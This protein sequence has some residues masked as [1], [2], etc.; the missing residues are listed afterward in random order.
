MELGL[1]KRRLVM[2]SLAGALR[3]MLAVPLYLVLTP[4]ML[5]ELGQEMFGLWS[6]STLIISVMTLTDFGFKNALVYHIARAQGQTEA[7]NGHFNVAFWTYLAIAGLIILATA[8]LGPLIVE[9][10]LRVP[11]RLGNE[12]WFVLWVT[13][14][15]FGLRFIAIPYQAVV[16]G[17]QQHAVAQFILL[18]WLIVNFIGS[19][20]AL[21]LYHNIYALGV[22]SVFSNVV[23]LA[24][25]FWRVST[26]Y[27]FVRLGVKYLKR[28]KFIDMLRFGSGIQIATVLI[29][30]REPLLKVLIA[31]V[32]DLTA[33]AS[34]E[35]VYRLCTQLVSLVA[36]PLLGSFSASALLAE[37]REHELQSIIRTMFGFCVAMFV[38]AILFF[39]TFSVPIIEFWLGASYPQVGEM[40]PFAFAAFAIYYTTEPLYKALEGAGLSGYSAL[41]QLIS[42][43]VSFAAFGRLVDYPAYAT[44]YALLTGFAVF[45]VSNY[46]VF[47]WRFKSITLFT[48]RQGLWLLGPILA[49]AACYSTLPSEALPMV[50][51]IYLA[52]HVWCVRKATIFDLI[53]IARRLTGLIR[54]RA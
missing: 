14:L 11:E 51:M 47:R 2:G 16:E 3:V 4:F 27:P 46:V 48:V 41:V 22:V 38:P 30:I 1:L 28:E 24:A 50:F 44:S 35:I 18:A 42:V 9:D 7:I 17:N 45:S 8:L 13:A 53:G 26:H 52:A 43:T 49:Y 54:A 36:T 40:L 32:Y 12:A 31:R 10:I 29:T 25:F 21:V 34:F 39:W 5:R 33:V 6:F 23:I 20:I 15:S 19:V 37:H